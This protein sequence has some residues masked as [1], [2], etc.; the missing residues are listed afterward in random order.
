MSGP[1]TRRNPRNAA[2]IALLFSVSAH[3][4]EGRG[5]VEVRAH[6][7]VGVDGEPVQ[8]IERVRPELAAEISDRVA[9]ST[10]VELG[11]SQGRNLQ[12]EVERTLTESDLGPVLDALGCT[13]PEPENTFLGIS[14]AEDYLRV[15]RLYLD[16]YLPQ[17]DLRLGRQAL[18]WGSA[19]LVNPTDPFPEVLLVEPWRPRAGVNALRATVPVGEGHQL[20]AV[21]GTDDTFRKVRLAGRA[22]MN[23]L[24]TDF[25]LV[26]AWR[27]ESDEGLVGLDIRGTLGVGFW[28]EGAVHLRE[29]PYEEVAVGVDYSF[30]VLD[31][32]VVTGQYY[33]NGAGSKEVD[34]EDLTNGI[35]AA[36]EPPDCGDAG[37]LFTAAEPD[38]FAPFFRGRDYGLLSVLL[39]FSPEVSATA[40]WVQN[41]GDGS[42]LIVPVLSTFPTGWLEVS[43]A[44]Q[45]PLSL[46][47][48]GGELHPADDDLV[49]AVDTG[50]DP[51]EVD[52]SGLVPDATLILWT[53]LNF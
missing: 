43:L 1:A 4:Q 24:D 46:W 47:G 42:G 15:E 31:T 28:V 36:I 23:A 52:L 11:L 17:A 53:R 32:L 19:V 7:S 49:W 16:V 10:T 39:A 20:Q 34:P 2:A 9:L 48:D 29:D 25:S 50:G 14:A 18:Q 40:L 13:W 26:S 41:L 27:Q 30:P 37:D 45:I 21:V 5:F 22:T 6:A 35:G 3:A 51:I 38:P 44:G 12:D 8:V 33:R